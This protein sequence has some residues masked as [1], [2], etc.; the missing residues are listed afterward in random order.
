MISELFKDLNIT[1]VLKDTMDQILVR[2]NVNCLEDVCVV[3]LT[4]S[5]VILAQYLSVFP[6]ELREV[7][8]DS[9]L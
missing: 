9:S 8:M 2:A 7:G 5:V 6:T 1:E 3:S 4:F